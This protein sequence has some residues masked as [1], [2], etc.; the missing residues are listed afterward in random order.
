MVI[1]EE[2]CVQISQTIDQVRLRFYLRIKLCSP[3]LKL[4]QDMLRQ[5]VDV[6]ILV[7]ACTSR[8]RKVPLAVTGADE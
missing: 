2:G 4:R 7:V 6:L 1:S 8:Q 5:Q 3:T